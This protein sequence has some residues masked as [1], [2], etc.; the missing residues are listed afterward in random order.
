M[1]PHNSAEIPVLFTNGAQ[2]TWNTLQ[3]R[4]FLMFYASCTLADV[5]YSIFYTHEL[6]QLWLVLAR[7][8]RRSPQLFPV[9][10]ISV[11]ISPV[12]RGRSYRLHQRCACSPAPKVCLQH[13]EGHQSSIIQSPAFV[14]LRPQCLVQC[15]GRILLEHCPIGC[16]SRQPL[17]MTASTDGTTMMTPGYHDSSPPI[18]HHGPW[19]L[20]TMA[21]EFW[22]PRP[23]HKEV[24]GHRGYQIR[25]VLNITAIFH[26][27]EGF[28]VP[29][30][31]K[32]H[33][34]QEN[35]TDHWIL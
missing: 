19:V 26:I 35:C 17:T 33:Q 15:F 12:S 23:L 24:G 34:Q 4:L 30:V 21:P 22:S 2:S 8:P 32:L 10:H 18:G 6:I 20:V 5:D 29:S 27:C 1:R 13:V 16:W 25:A 9:S 7:A 28:I 14:V 3:N 11:V 31:C